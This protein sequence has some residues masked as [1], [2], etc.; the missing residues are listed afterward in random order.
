MCLTFRAL[1]KATATQNLRSEAARKPIY[2][3]VHSC[4]ILFTA[5]IT[6]RNYGNH[7]F[8]LSDVRLPPHP[9]PRPQE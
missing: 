7:L 8:N 4:F 1:F 3:L 9:H 5:L 2:S 6:V